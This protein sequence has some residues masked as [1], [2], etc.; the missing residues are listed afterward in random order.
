MC[1]LAVDPERRNVGEHCCPG[2]GGQGKDGVAETSESINSRRGQLKFGNQ[3][4]SVISAAAGSFLPQTQNTK[5]KS[6]IPVVHTYQSPL[7]LADM[8]AA[9]CNSLIALSRTTFQ[10]VFL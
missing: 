1:F 9:S 7:P 3:F 5:N 6:C 10:M 2:G 8:N 4:P